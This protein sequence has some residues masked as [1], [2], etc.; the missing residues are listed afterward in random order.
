MLVTVFHSRLLSGVKDVV[1][2]CARQRE[3][4]AK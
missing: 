2:G 1:H 4:E 3:A